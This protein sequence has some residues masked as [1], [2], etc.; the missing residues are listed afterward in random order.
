MTDT[1]TVP[2]PAP[3]LPDPPT[4]YCSLAQAAARLRIDLTAV[5]PDPDLDWL[6]LC[7]QYACQQIDIYF[8]DRPLV[9]GADDTYPPGVVGAAIG[10]T[11]LAFRGKDAMSDVSEEWSEQI[12]VRIPRVPLDAY[13]AWLAGWRWGGS[14]SPA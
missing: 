1:P 7:W 3:I 8:L 11:T 2:G 13:E 10:I 12:P 6:T 5:P 4:A 14:W 9:A